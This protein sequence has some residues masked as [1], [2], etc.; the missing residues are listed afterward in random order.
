MTVSSINYQ[1]SITAVAVVVATELVLVLTEG[2]VDEV[3]APPPPPPQ[4]VIPRRHTAIAKSR[5]A[6]FHV[7]VCSSAINDQLRCL[8]LAYAD[9]AAILA[10]G[11]FIVVLHQ[12]CLS[13]IHRQEVVGHGSAP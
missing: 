4:D 2:V 3:V 10:A 9:S 7:I 6:I 11:G 13:S 12:N 1:E 5:M 8:E